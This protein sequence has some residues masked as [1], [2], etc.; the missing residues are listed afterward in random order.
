M[1][2]FSPAPHIERLPEGAN[3][4]HLQ[5]SS[6]LEVFAGTFIGYATFYLIRQNFSLAVPF[7]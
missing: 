4:F 2:I 5:T 3:R 7:T 6:S 1:S